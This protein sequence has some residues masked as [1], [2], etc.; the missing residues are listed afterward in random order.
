[1][2]EIDQRAFEN[3]RSIQ[4][5]TFE[6]NPSLTKIGNWAFFLCIALED[7]EIPEG[8]TE[9]GDGAFYG[10]A[11]LKDL[12]LPNSVQSVGDNTFALCSK[13]Q[14]MIVRAVTPPDIDSKTF[15]EVSRQIPVYVPDESLADYQH[16]PLWHEF[17]IQG[18]SNVPTGIDNTAF[19]TKTSKILRNGQIFIL[20]GEKVY[21]VTGQEVK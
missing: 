6:E 20:R 7:L 3:C 18:I 11:Y 19:E 10:C 4:H 9:I 14:N 15:D 5:V 2:V 17:F 21:S 16:H 1:V 12:V 8:V 13:L